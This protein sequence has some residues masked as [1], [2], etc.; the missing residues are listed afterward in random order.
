MI[1]FVVKGVVNGFHCSECAW[2]LMLEQP[3]SIPTLRAKP[4][5]MRP[6]TGTHRTTAYDSQN[7]EADRQTPR[8]I[9][10]E[11]SKFRWT[12]RILLRH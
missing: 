8:D 11:L 5:P 9:I 10:E 7:P 4:G 6:C 1:P 2:A 3:S 12:D